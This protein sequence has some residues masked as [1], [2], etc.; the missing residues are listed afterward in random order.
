MDILSKFTEQLCGEFNND[1]QIIQEEKQGKIIHPKAKH[2]NGI[3]NHKINNLPKDFN[4]YFIIEESYYEQGTFKNILPHL[5]L[6]TLNENKNI[7]LTSYEL[8]SGISKEDFR[9]D[10]HDLTMDYNQLQKSEKFTPMI[11]TEN[12]G[13]F[14][15]ESISFFTPETKFVLKETVTKNTLSVSEVFYKNDKIT[16]GFINPIVYDKIK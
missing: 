8:P 1:N 9:N 2:I 5:F 16:I 13:V 14:T 6:F 15:G 7:V 12:N 10:N 3:C 4:G 11:Y